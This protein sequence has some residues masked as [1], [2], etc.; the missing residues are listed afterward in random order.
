M[1]PPRPAFQILAWECLSRLLWGDF[2]WSL[3]F[4]QAPKAKV[5]TSTI[6]LASSL[7]VSQVVSPGR[8]SLTGVQG[9][10][11]HG[12]CAREGGTLAPCC[13]VTS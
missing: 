8:A 13:A 9:M 5:S 6:S 7:A 12:P 10:Q 4:T 3:L 2:W 1:Q 11:S